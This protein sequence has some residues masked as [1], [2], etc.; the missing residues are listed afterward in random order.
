MYI[1]Y[2]VCDEGPLLLRSLLDVIEAKLTLLKPKENSVGPQITQGKANIPLGFR[3][4]KP[5][6]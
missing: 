3:A 4:V 5:R 2:S 1:I 6:I